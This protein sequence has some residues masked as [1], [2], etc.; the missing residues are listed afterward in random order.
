[1]ALT[2][3]KFILLKKRITSSKEQRSQKRSAN[4]LEKWAKLQNRK[5]SYKGTNKILIREIEVLC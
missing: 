5:T 1:M 4:I 2:L 3:E